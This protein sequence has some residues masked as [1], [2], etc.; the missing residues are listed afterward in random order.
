MCRAGP[1]CDECKEA[2]YLLPAPDSLGRQQ[3]APCTCHEDGAEAA[4]CEDLTGQVTS[5][6]AMLTSAD[7]RDLSARVG[8]AWRGCGATR[9]RSS[10]GTSPR[11]GGARVCRRAGACCSVTAQSCVISNTLL[12]VGNTGECVQ[13]S[14]SCQCKEHVQGENCDQCKPGYF[15]V[16]NDNIHPCTNNT[17]LLRLTRRTCSAAPPASAAG[18]PRTARWPRATSKV[19][20]RSSSH[21]FHRISSASIKSQFTRGLEDWT[22]EEE[23]VAIPDRTVF[24]AYKKMVGLQA[25]AGPAHFVAPRSFLGQQLASYGQL[26]KFKLKIG[27]SDGRR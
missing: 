5:S 20:S 3:C 26:L 25:V 4:Q 12:S 7:L 13:Q 8:R 2:H 23:G 6:C 11:V 16:D 9:V 14:G 27:P 1:R 21:V 17:P 15:Q 19:S 10:A 18:T 24:N 22:A